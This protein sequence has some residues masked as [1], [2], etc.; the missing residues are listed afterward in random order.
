MMMSKAAALNASLRMPLIAAPLFLV[1]NPKLVIA[2][3]AAGVVG[4]FPALNARKADR[5]SDLEAWLCE[6]E[7]GLDGVKA[8]F[9]VNQIVH[10]SNTRLMSDMEIIVRHKVRQQGCCCCFSP[11]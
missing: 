8:P 2:Q 5:S 1:S 3:C 10:K 11:G 4:S 9:A 7:A 6:I